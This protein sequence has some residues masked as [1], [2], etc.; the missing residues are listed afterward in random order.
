MG[1]SLRLESGDDVAVGIHELASLRRVSSVDFSVG[2]HAP[3][4]SAELLLWFVGGDSYC[5]TH[6]YEAETQGDDSAMQGFSLVGLD[7]GLRETNRCSI[8]V[9][10][11]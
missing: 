9:R 6:K 1:R 2:L 8:L 11:W 7:D 10:W 4:E 3:F 5:S